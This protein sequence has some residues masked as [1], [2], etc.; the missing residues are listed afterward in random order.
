M[1]H[2][3]KQQPGWISL[4]VASEILEISPCV[5]R[6]EYKN[7]GISYKSFGKITLYDEVDVFL[8]KQK[9]LENKRIITESYSLVKDERV[10]PWYYVNKEGEVYSF[11]HDGIYGYKMIPSP[12]KY[13]YLHL[14]L[15]GPNKTRVNY[16]V[17]QLVA[18]AFLP[19]PN[20]YEIINHKNG[21]KTD[22]RLENLEWC[23]TQENT[24]HAMRT[25]LHRH[26]YEGKITDKTTVPV[27]I[28]EYTKEKG[29]IFKGIFESATIAA[30]EIGVDFF[31]F[32]DA[33]DEKVKGNP[34]CVRENIF[35]QKLTKQQ[36]RAIEKDSKVFVQIINLDNKIVYSSKEKEFFNRALVYAR[37]EITS[38]AKNNILKF[39]MAAL[40][41]EEQGKELEVT[42]IA[43]KANMA[44]G[45]IFYLIKSYF[46]FPDTKTGK[47]KI[48][49]LCRMYR[50]I[51]M[52]PP[53]GEA[54]QETQEE[55][56]EETVPN[57]NLES[58]GTETQ[59]NTESDAK[60]GVKIEKIFEV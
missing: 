33:Y 53:T 11:P 57:E 44:K 26:K 3:T 41:M 19:N 48:K 7:W 5:F 17:H 39:I 13:G 32:R 18:K 22:N 50:Q 43:K 6:K 55:T 56:G 9:L 40:V 27:L 14:G 24:A 10:F 25:H 52:M 28:Y 2:W 30:K 51:F 21:I 8:R 46:P 38:V 54:P 29:P 59:N 15:V 31:A 42:D 4:R 49:I 58:D 12:N 36:Y 37:R 35:C 16:V 34:G 45:T 47:D 60:E 23:T 20:Q 1:E